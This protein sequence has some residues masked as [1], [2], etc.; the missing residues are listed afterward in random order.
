MRQRRRSILVGRDA[1]V[2]G[3]RGS[4]RTARAP[5]RTYP[6]PG[7]LGA[8]AAALLGVAA[9]LA[10]AA[11]LHTTTMAGPPASPSESSPASS[12]ATE[13]LVFARQVTAG[14]STVEVPDGLV[15][16]A[17]HA[18]ESGT[19]ELKV[20]EAAGR[21]GTLAGPAV[22]LVV[23]R[24][25]GQPENDPRA[26]RDGVVRLVDD[27]LARA[28]AAPVPGDGRDVIGLLDATA[29]ALGPGPN[30]VWLA[31]FG[32]GT[33]D[34]AD[35]RILMA[36]DPGA[37]A[38]SIAGSVPALRGARVHVLLTAPAGTQPPLNARTEAWRAA[39]VTAVL[40]EGGATVVS[41]D[42]DLRALPPGPGASAVPAV[43]PLP[44]P[45]PAPAVVP[46][47]G[48]V[49][50]ALDSVALFR[51]DT[52]EF[53]DSDD[54]VAAQ[55]AP[56]VDGYRAGRFGRVGITGRCARFGDAAAARALSLARARTIADLLRRRGIP[57]ADPDV[58]GL[59]YDDPLPP[60]PRDPRN[61]SVTVTA[62]PTP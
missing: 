36:G 45:T 41:V 9:L 14:E 38:S 39:F 30:E 28:A 15:D 17:V 51:P 40:R 19:P 46:P 25:P 26:R 18:A 29:A 54:A 35:A 21:S 5:A 2:R 61:R 4:A 24:E 13:T 23:E 8:A 48:P 60:G 56:I 16:H 27:A 34:P 32:L 37:A 55:L 49:T 12:P 47:T 22:P 1:P 10:V 11:W 6:R 31:T 58:V 62:H 33:V 3:R 52:A 7:V 53:V 44:D 57:V 50:L 20:V 42:R 59:G 43:A